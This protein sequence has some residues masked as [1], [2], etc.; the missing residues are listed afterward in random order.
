MD[1]LALQANFLR[2]AEPI[3]DNYKQRIDLVGEVIKDSKNPRMGFTDFDKATLA[4]LYDNVEKELMRYKNLKNLSDRTYSEQVG[5]FKK[6][7]YN[8]ITAL[9][10]TLEIRDLVSFQPLTQKRGAIYKMIYQF[11]S[12]KG[13]IRAGDTMFAPGTMGKRARYYSSQVVDKEPVTWTFDG[14]DSLATL[15]YFPLSKPEKINIVVSGSP[16]AGTYTYLNTT[17]GIYILQKDAGGAD[18]GNLNPSTGVVTLTGVNATAATGTEGTY[19]WQSEKFSTNAPIPKVTVSITE[20]EVR[21][22]RRNLLIDTMLDVSYDFESQFAK[23]LN[24]ELESTV[25]QYLQNELAF[26]VLGEIYDG[27]TGNG[28]DT[29]SFDTTATAGL[30]LTDHAQVLY[31]LLAEMSAKVRN[32]IGRGWGNKII[33]GDDLI[34]FLKILPNDVW[35]RADKPKGDG[36]YFAGTLNGDYDIYYNPDYP[37]DEFLMTYKGDSWWEAPYYIGSYLPLMNS[38]YLLYPDMHGEQGYIAMEA[39]S[40]EYPAMVVKG[41]LTSS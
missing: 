16:A 37:A 26:R 8:I 9:Y 15:E 32:N 12:N 30:S 40:Y 31:K 17:N 38:Q 11:A 1:Y 25:I 28:G 5:P 24:S 36:P 10:T 34:N 20:D 27:Q 23:S 29:F 22:E 35:K 14:T 7:A 13:N 33:C 21:A 4:L 18:V 6:H 19:N 39:Y 3:V 41:T 2:E